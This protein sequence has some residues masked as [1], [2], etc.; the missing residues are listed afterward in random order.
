LEAGRKFGFEIK[1]HENL[2]I[3]WNYLSTMGCFC[4]IF[5]ASDYFQ[6]GLGCFLLLPKSEGSKVICPQ[7]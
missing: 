2:I 1:T 3:V 4:C 5:A 6:I 7:V